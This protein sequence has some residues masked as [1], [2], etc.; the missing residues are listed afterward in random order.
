MEDLTFHGAKPDALTGVRRNPPAALTPGPARRAERALAAAQANSQAGALDAALALLA[1][2][3]VGPLD[4]LRAAQADLLRGRIAFAANWGSDAPPLL[5][6]AARRLERLDPRLT[7]ETYLDA[8]TAAMFAAQL[9]PG[10]LRGWPR[11]SGRHRRRR[12]LRARPTCC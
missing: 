9:A 2:A 5:L 7:R 11:P 10:G 6:K 3:E 1:T 4:E 12:N 8:L